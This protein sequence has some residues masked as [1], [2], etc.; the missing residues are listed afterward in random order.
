MKNHVLYHLCAWFP[1]AVM[2][3]AS[4]QGVSGSVEAPL[5]D[6]YRWN[7]PLVLCAGAFRVLR[8]GGRLFIDN[9]DLEQ[10]AGW[11]A[12]ANGAK[13]SQKLERTPYIPTPST[14]SELTTYAS[15]RLCPDRGA[16]AVAARDHYCS[17]ASCRG[18]I[19]LWSCFD[20]RHLPES[21]A[22]TGDDSTC[23]WASRYS[24]AQGH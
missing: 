9:T 20:W 5:T 10:D 4:P 12:F 18:I 24:I 14:A 13:S 2:R 8:P 7:G 11:R 15:R 21:G 22:R 23:P 17:Q 6:R 1:C 3:T 16:Q 19:A